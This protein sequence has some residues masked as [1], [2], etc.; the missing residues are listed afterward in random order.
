MQY[1]GRSVTLTQSGTRVLRGTFVLVQERRGGETILQSYYAVR[2]T[3]GWYRE[4]DFDAAGAVDEQRT[5]GLSNGRFLWTSV[6]KRGESYEM[7]RDGDVV[8]FRFF[9]LGRDRLRH[10][11]GRATCRPLRVPR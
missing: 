10:E 3:G 8:R 9:E 2:A 7:R 4:Y 6:S 5:P 11:T 1:G